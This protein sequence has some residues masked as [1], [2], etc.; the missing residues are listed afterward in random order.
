MSLSEGLHLERREDNP[1]SYDPLARTRSTV[2]TGSSTVL[3]DSFHKWGIGKADPHYYRS[4]TLHSDYPWSQSPGYSMYP[5]RLLLCAGISVYLLQVPIPENLSS[6]FP[7]STPVLVLGISFQCW[8][9]YAP[10]S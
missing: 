4:A 8:L 5:S 10:P 9:G 1:S 2:G 3:G 6:V 7:D